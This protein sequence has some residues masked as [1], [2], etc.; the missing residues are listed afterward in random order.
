MSLLAQMKPRHYEALLRCCKTRAYAFGK[1]P[2]FVMQLRELTMKHDKNFVKNAARRVTPAMRNALLKTAASAMWWPWQEIG[3]KETVDALIERR[4]I[5]AAPGDPLNHHRVRA[6][7]LGRAVLGHL[8]RSS[9][10]L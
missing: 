4:L 7:P 3:R 10:I 6:T 2:R 8:A 9:E 1:D 5:E